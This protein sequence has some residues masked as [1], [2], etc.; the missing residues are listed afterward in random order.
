MKKIEVISNGVIIGYTYGE[1]NAIEFLDNKEA[2]IVKDKLYKGQP[3]GISSR[4]MGTIDENG[5]C[6]IGELN[7]L[8]IVNLKNK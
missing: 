5:K 4:K 6:I 1:G 3:V 8:G 7:E 2:F